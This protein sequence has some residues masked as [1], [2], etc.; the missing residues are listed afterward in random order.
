MQDLQPAIT[1]LE[2]ALGV[3][4]TNAPINES[5]GKQEQAELERR[6]AE[7]YRAAIERLKSE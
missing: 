4:E 7:S 1:A 3:V 5:E 2:I 6:N